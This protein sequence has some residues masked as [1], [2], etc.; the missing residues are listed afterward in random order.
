M[1]IEKVDINAMAGATPMTIADAVVRECP[2]KEILEDVVY[3]INAYITR[4]WGNKT[5]TK[6]NEDGR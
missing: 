1:T 5:L 3:Y 4:E 2:D 6:E